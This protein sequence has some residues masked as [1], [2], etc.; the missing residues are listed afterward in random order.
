M[1]FQNYRHKRH[2]KKWGSKNKGYFQ[3]FDEKIVAW[4][5][6]LIW[7]LNH[8]I[9]KYWFR[10]VLRIH[11]DCKWNETIDKLSPNS[12][13]VPSGK[14]KYK[15]DFRTHN[16]FS[17]RLYYAFRPLWWTL[18]AVDW[19]MNKFG[20]WEQEEVTWVYDVVDDVKEWKA[21]TMNDGLLFIERKFKW[22][23][24]INFG[25]DTLTVYPDAHPETTT[26]DGMIVRDETDNWANIRSASSGSYLYDTFGEGGLF[27]TAKKDGN[28]FRIDR[29]FILFDTSSLTAGA[30]I[31]SAVISLFGVEKGESD[32]GF[33]SQYVVSSSP[34][35]NTTLVVGDYDQVGSTSYSNKS[36]ANYSTSAYND[37][38][39]NSNGLDAISKANVSKYGWRIY[40]DFEN[41]EPAGHNYVRANAAD[42][43]GTSSDPKLVVTYTLPSTGNQY[44]MII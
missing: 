11:K 24:F 17:K 41:T 3:V 32:P 35:S 8:P 21:G 31:S 15:Q 29:C 26:I 5:D 16:K 27:I 18:H 12:Y 7:L 40:A 33:S 28:N 9:L 42:T 34:A 6:K 23:P 4:Q 43:P 14:G 1:L 22:R 39:L 30:V 20:K 10:W 13:R 2:I 37:Y 36:Y 19:V 44:Q 38:A 25:F